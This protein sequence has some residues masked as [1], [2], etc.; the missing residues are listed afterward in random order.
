MHSLGSDLVISHQSLVIGS[1]KLKDGVEMLGFVLS[2]PEVLR[3][4]GLNPTYEL[5]RSS[6]YE[7]MLEW[8]EKEQGLFVCH[9][10]QYFAEVLNKFVNHDSILLIRLQS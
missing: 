9:P 8:Y 7:K 2:E 6:P 3:A 4:G 1:S 10:Q 5:G